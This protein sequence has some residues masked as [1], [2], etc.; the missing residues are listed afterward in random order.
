LSGRERLFGRG[1]SAEGAKLK[2]YGTEEARTLEIVATGLPPDIVPEPS[3][4]SGTKGRD[5]T[6]R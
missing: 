3:N 5:R 1:Y 2:L 4:R 6:P